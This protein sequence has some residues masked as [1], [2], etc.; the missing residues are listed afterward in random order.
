MNR[1]LKILLCVLLILTVAISVGLGVASYVMARQD[2]EHAKFFNTGK[3]VNKFLS[4][5]NHALQAAFERKDAATVTRFYSDKY[6]SPG[7]GHWVHQPDRAESDVAISRLLVEGAQDYRKADVQREV[8]EYINGLV[9]IDD[10]KFKI[11]MIQ[12]VELER[13]VELTVKFILD[14]KDQQGALF[15]DRHFYR[16]HL[17]NEGREGYDWKIIKDELVEGVRVAGD[18]RGFTELKPADIG[19]DYTHKRDPKLNAKQVKLKF[20]V[21]EHGTGG[22]SAADFD[23]DNRPDIFFADGERSRLYRNETEPGASALRFADVTRQAGLD[24]IGHATAGIFAD[25][26]NDGASDLVVVRYLEP[27]RFF[28]NNCDGTFTDASAKF[29]LDKIVVPGI[30]ACFLDY[31]RDGFVDLYVSVYG[32]AFQDVPRLPFFAQNGGK[33]RLLRNDDG[34][35]FTDVS[36]TSG[37]GDTGW[38]LA[39]A[40]A[41]YDNDGWLDLVVANDFG[42]KNLYRN[43][44]DGT[45]TEDAKHAGVLDFSGGMG[46]AWGDF[47]DDGNLDLYTSNINSN[48]RWF[49]KDQTIDQYMR[50]VFRTRWIA[51]DAGQYW[52]FYQLV[53]SR[54][55]EIGT[56]IGEGNSLFAN[57]RDGTFRELKDSHTSRAGWGWSVAFFDM[58][59][60]T[61]ICDCPSQV[62][63]SRT[64]TSTNRA[65]FSA[66][67]LWAKTPGTDTNATACSP[68]R[69]AVSSLMWPVRRDQI[70]SVTVAALPS[71]TLMA[72]DE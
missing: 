22:V 51:K 37:V 24:G 61:T 15:Q 63:R 47:N 66:K 8:G 17:V 7:R 14:G 3:S 46:V 5:Y 70:A 44:G 39:V 64:L 72:T 59:N 57:N 42:R 20:G 21:I 28:R 55:A 26:D 69:A 29:G 48:Q 45:F 34:H 6:V 43:N 12:Q 62:A 58:D 23:N 56:Q 27:L 19:I 11:D 10:I 40:S 4:D 35:G 36:D 65:H 25:V 71:P 68:T 50:N 1:K 52:D 54:W 41:D 38:S 33:N 67:N 2:T 60:D 30:S 16:W 9:A 31:N 18:A 13:S 49:G 32:N 53:G